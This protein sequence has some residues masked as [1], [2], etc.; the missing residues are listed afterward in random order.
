MRFASS[1]AAGPSRRCRRSTSTRRLACARWSQ[2][3][4]LVARY[5][6]TGCHI[7]EGQGGDIRR[8]YEDN[9]SQAP[10]N[11]LGEGQKVQ[12]PWLFNFLKAPYPI[13]PWLQVRMPT[14]GFGDD[15]A[16]SLVRYF[17]AIDHL[18]VPFVHIEKAM[19]RPDYVHA[20]EQLA[21]KDYFSCLSCHV[22]G[23]QKPEGS[24]DSWAPDLA[25]AAQR[26]YPDWIVRV[27]ARSRRS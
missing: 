9:L 1:C 24:P 18:E 20:G 26:L 27:A 14:F 25:M 10:P 5:N 7:I 13:R 8:L 23:D 11:L 3:R 15:H 19:L 4:R 2:G 17:G 21:S 16:T 6:C 12:Q 22:R